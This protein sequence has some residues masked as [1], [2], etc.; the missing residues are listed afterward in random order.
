MSGKGAKKGDLKKKIVH[1][2]TEYWINVCYLTL[3]FAAFTQYRRFLLAAH[4]ITYTNYGF[5]VIEALV[6]A[7]VIMIGEVARLG[8]GLE[9]KPL[10]YPTL[11]KTV[12]FTLFVGVFTLIEHGIKGLWKGEG[13][14]SGIADFLGKGF[15]EILAN[16]IIVFIAFIPFFGIKELGRVLGEDKIR[17]LFFRRRADQ[18]IVGS[19]PGSTP[20]GSSRS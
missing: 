20:N 8:R 18:G 11:Y 12:V 13:F 1:E 9:R 19:G 2:V 16:S 5:A 3:V 6:L 15:N 10:I 17:A 7:K 4:D 14:T